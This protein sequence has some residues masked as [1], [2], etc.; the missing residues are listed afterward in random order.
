MLADRESLVRNSMNLECLNP[1]VTIGLH[2]VAPAYF[3][4]SALWLSVACITSTV[5]DPT[6]PDAT[7][8]P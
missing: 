8:S 5:P 6:E 4:R 2:P 1:A 7:W 3:R